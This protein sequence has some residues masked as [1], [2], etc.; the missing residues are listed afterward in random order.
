MSLRSNVYAVA[1]GGNGL[2]DQLKSQFKN[3]QFILDRC[4]LKQHLY[5]TAEALGLSGSKK[6]NLV[7]AQLKLI[8]GGK[9]QQLLLNLRRY[10]EPGSTT[11]TE[12]GS[13]R[14]SR[15]CN[16]LQRFSDCV[17]YDRFIELGLPIG[18]GEIES[19]HRYIPQKRLKIAGATWHPDNI[20]P[21]LSLLILQANNWWSDFWQQFTG[22]SKIPA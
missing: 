14:L 15:L 2:Y 8:D 5:E 18:S 6:H 20:N 22:Q 19:A 16:Y 9:V 4:H 10:L 3:L 17:N 12:F 1:D 11:L 7:R 21:M 13:A